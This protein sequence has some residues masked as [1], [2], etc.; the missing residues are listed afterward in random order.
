[1]SVGGG[2]LNDQSS[3]SSFSSLNLNTNVHFFVMTARWSVKN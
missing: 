2:V 3:S 1:V